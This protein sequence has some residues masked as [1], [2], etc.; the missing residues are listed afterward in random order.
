MKKQAYTVIALFVLAVSM[1][2]AA[3][4]QTS[5]RTQLVATI[6]FQFVAGDKTLPAGEYTVTE[7]NT[8]S[9]RIALQL[10][11]KDGASV[12]LTT[13]PVI[14]RAQD[15]SKLVFHRYGNQHFFSQVWLDGENTG[16]QA[17][18]AKAERMIARETNSS[19]PAMETVAISRQR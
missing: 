12:L 3:Q 11:S 5:G 8:S 6:P 7:V 9:D 16:L 2:V 1:A 17:P 13:M 18:E 14:A 4:A 15:S 19:K 10:R